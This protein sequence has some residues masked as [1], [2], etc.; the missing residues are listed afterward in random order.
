MKYFCNEFFG[1]EFF[2]WFGEWCERKCIFGK[3][4]VFEICVC[5]YGYWGLECLNI[6]FGGVVNLCNN[7]G[8]CN[9]IMGECECNVNY[10]GM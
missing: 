3:K 1:R 8:M 6:C 2:I 10:N 5:Y 9:V 4:L 7:N